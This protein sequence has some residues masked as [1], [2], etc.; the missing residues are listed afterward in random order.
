MSSVIYALFIFE[1]CAAVFICMSA[2]VM[3]IFSFLGQPDET[4]EDWTVSKNQ[5]KY[6]ESTSFIS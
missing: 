2:D 1:S 5:T 3:L 4:T 6:T